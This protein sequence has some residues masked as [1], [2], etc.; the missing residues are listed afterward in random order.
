MIPFFFFLID[1]FPLSKNVAEQSKGGLIV[2]GGDDDCVRMYDLVNGKDLGTLVEHE[3]SVTCLDMYGPAGAARPTHLFSG[4][5]DGLVNVWRVKDFKIL[6]RLRGHKRGVKSLAVHQSGKLALSCDEDT[7]LCM[8]N[9]V[10][11][12]VSYKN[13]LGSAL[14]EIALGRGHNRYLGRMRS[15]LV[16]RDLEDPE[17]D[18]VLHP[19]QG[20]VLQSMCY[21]GSNY[22]YSGCADGTVQL[23]D[24]RTSARSHELK[25]HARRVKGIAVPMDLA[26]NESAGPSGFQNYFVSA[27]SEGDLKIW[28]AR[29]LSE[30]GEKAE[31][32]GVRQLGVRL[33]CLCA[34]EGSV[35][36]AAAEMEEE[37]DDESE[38]EDEEE[39]QR[40][41]KRPVKRPAKKIKKKQ[42]KRY[43]NMA[44]F[45]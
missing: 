7:N 34:K 8:W 16:V 41:A 2:S 23:W 44:R 10:K 43:A 15:E 20:K 42:N 28:D 30:D 31:P 27:S 22:A 5:S 29:M 13:K 1:H 25:A 45:D 39:M 24:L 38:K 3:G 14:E 18:S 19:G 26:G 35:E 21:P 17:V 4:G 12:R 37:E 11:G 9:L 6:S 32:L 40:P 36:G 33:T